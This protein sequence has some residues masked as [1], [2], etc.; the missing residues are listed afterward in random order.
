MM[1]M[2]K[3]SMSSSGHE[4]RVTGF[5]KPAN[6]WQL[7]LIMNIVYLNNIQKRIY[8]NFQKS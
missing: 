3:E 5:L 8:E 6:N 2:G 4:R 7:V 1:S